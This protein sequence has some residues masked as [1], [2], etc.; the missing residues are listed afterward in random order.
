MSSFGSEMSQHCKT[1]SP[2][3]AAAENS[4]HRTRQSHVH[5]VHAMVLHTLHG[6]HALL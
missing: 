2:F 5:A 6:V 1:S 4:T 3:A